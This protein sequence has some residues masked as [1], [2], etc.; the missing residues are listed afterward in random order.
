MAKTAAESICRNRSRRS[1]AK[2][3]RPG[4]QRRC[5]RCAN[6]PRPGARDA[7]RNRPRR[8]AARDADAAAR[9]APTPPP[10]PATPRPSR[11]G[12]ARTR[13]TAAARHECPA[14]RG[15][16]AIER[17]AG[18]APG[19]DPQHDPARERGGDRVHLD[20]PRAGAARISA[21]SPN[22]SR[23]AT[24]G[25]ITAVAA[26]HISAAAAAGTGAASSAAVRRL[27]GGARAS[28]PPRLGEAGRSRYARSARPGCAPRSAPARRFR[29]SG[30][31]CAHNCR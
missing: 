2:H 24:P 23:T 12:A 14:G 4:S 7:G 11:A 5:R 20:P 8:R 22:R 30:G 16:T 13:R 21:G 10:R 25:A 31:P 28:T 9:A 19:R 3:L 27:R 6:S 18:A 26:R 29:R 1:A 15:G 17:A